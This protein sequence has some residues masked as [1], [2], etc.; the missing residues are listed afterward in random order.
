M[1]EKPATGDDS[2]TRQELLEEVR[3]LRARLAESEADLQATNER[4]QTLSRAIN[5]GYWEWDETVKRAAHFSREMADILGMSLEAL[6][7]IY[8]CEEDFFKYVHPDDLPHYIAN[9]SGVLDPDHPRGQ[10]YIFEYRIVRPNGELRYVRELEYG[11]REVDGETVHSYGAIQDVTDLHESTRARVESEQRYSSLFS[12]LPLGAQEQDWSAIK[13]A[14]DKLQSEGVGDLKA[15]LLDNPSLLKELVASI[16]ITSANDALLKIYGA[17]SA[18]EYIEDEENSSD[19]L[20]EEWSELYASEIATLA[21]PVKIHYAELAEQRWDGSSFQTRLI[22]SVVEGDEDSWNRVLTIVED[23][24]DRKQNEIDLLAAKEAA[25]QASKAKSEF[26]ATMS[27]EIRTPMNGVLG[28]TELLMDSDLDTRARRLA[29]TAH[30]S[31]ESLLEIINDILDFSKIEADK[32][33]LAEDD[34]DLREMLEDVLEMI[35]GQAHRKGLECIGD[36]PPDLPRQVCGDAVRLRQVMVNLLGN[37]VKFTRD[38]EIRLSARVKQ[39]N[40]DSFEM[41]FEVSDTGDGIPLEQHDTIF[42]AFDQIESGASRRF[43]G[44]GL[45]LAITCRLVDLMAGRIDL[46]SAPGTG[47]L[48]RLTLPLAVAGEEVPQPQSPEILAGLRILIVDDHP[49][50]REILHNQVISWGM[51]N[52]NVDSG[53]RAIANIRQAQAENDPYQI[54]LLD[55]YMPDM[56]GLEL[57]KTLT[58]DSSI[59]TPQLV[60]L[61]SSGFDTSSAIAKKASISLHLQ[62]PVRQR[63]LQDCLCEAMGIRQSGKRLVADQSVQFEGNILLAED[64]QVNQE[65]AIGMLM[66]LGCNADLA[67]N[68]AAAVIAARNKRYDLIL[69]DCHMPEMNG[70]EASRKLREHEKQHDL[71]PTPIVALTADVKKG[72]EDECAEAG[73]DGYI[74]K[75][76]SKSRLEAI[77]DQ[78]LNVNEPAADGSATQSADPVGATEEKVIDLDVLGELKSLSQTTGRDILGKSVNF[79]LEQAPEDVAVMRLAA[80]QADLEVIGNLAHSL[81]SSSAN[82]GATGLSK[83]CAALEAS[84]RE[85][86][87]ELSLT[88]IQSVESQLPAVLAELRQHVEVKQAAAPDE[89]E[90]LPAIREVSA[91]TVLVVDDDNGFRLTTC[92]A[93]KGTG[94]DVIEAASGEDALSL[95]EEAVPDLVLLDAIMPGLDGFEVCRKLRSK[96]STRAIPV[97]ILTGLGDMESVNR[98]FESGATDFIVKPVNYALLS[99]R[100]QFQLRVAGNLR[101]LH[102]TQEW[103]SSAQ[104]IAGVGYWQWDSNSDQITVSEQLAAM[105]LMD[106]PSSIRSLDDY[107]KFVHPQDQEFIRSKILSASS[108]GSTS[109]DDYRL[110]TLRSDTIVVHQELAQPSDSSHIVLGTVQDITLQRESENRIRQLAYSDELTGLASRAYFHKHLEDVIKASHRRSERFALLFIDLDG[111]KKVNDSLGHDAGDTLLKVIAKRLQDL[112]RDTDFVARLSGDEFCILVDNISDQYGAAYVAERCLEDMNVPVSLGRQNIRPRCSIG[113]A[114]YPDDGEDSR[115]LLKAADSAMYA[116]K[117]EGK[118]RYVYYQPEFTEKAE[119]RVRIEQD[120]RLAIDNQ[121]LELHYQPQVDLASGRMT[122]VEALVRWNHPTRGLLPPGEFIDTAE[123]IGFIKPLGQWVLKTACQQAIAWKDRGVPELQ[124]SVNISTSH[125]L[126]IDFVD[127]VEMVLADSGFPARSLQLEVT[128]SVIQPSSDNTSVFSRLQEM[129]IRIAI[130]D[131]GTGY[132]SLASLKHLPIDCLKIDRMFIK[133]MLQNPKTSILLGTIIGAAHALGHTIVAEGVE[134]EDQVKVLTAIGSDLI[135]GYHFSRPVP[136]DEIPELADT[137]FLED[138]NPAE[139]VLP[140]KQKT[141]L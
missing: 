60:L 99:S 38:G 13:Q 40:V 51:R 7:E 16:R 100:I 93:L 81:K 9:L 95:I 140:L 68:G 57:A 54:V 123:R 102:I 120:L 15:H 112:V 86:N 98:A 128:E 76:F 53:S 44:T 87:K 79:F 31:A 65:V 71:P 72:I 61:S 27:H 119:D 137:N 32:M 89:S 49:T 101:E 59:Q 124:L 107:L 62:K 116:A 118:H 50:N 25:E 90:Q 132:S 58:E 129:G 139:V 134:E 26:L 78:W 8:Q 97:M 5:I 48:F 34:F 125:F 33:E 138:D 56:D 36:L 24:T 127:M 94:Y 22:T 1:T 96:P 4:H 103:L 113:I 11:T 46:E 88:L 74:S 20:D 12:K 37:A 110:L 52:D 66:A 141:A 83:S 91:P 108:T 115:S 23:V 105:L 41:V 75:P 70:F 2:K 131:F 73:M 6:Y 45:G 122:G 3:G 30:R 84:A 82:L 21:G 85:G 111:F 133:D 63:L 77:L 10:A 14:V 121:E 126:D 42:N 80:K 114:Y 43:G 35:A 55:W 17:A 29:T 130:D 64:N 47:S 67:E 106:E 135:Q 39:R 69:M 19:W 92:E 18:E 109:S 28:M 136:A 104:R 117:H